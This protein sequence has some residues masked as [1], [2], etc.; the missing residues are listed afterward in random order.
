MQM[1]HPKTLE[2]LVH[3]ETVHRLSLAFALFLHL[4]DEIGECNLAFLT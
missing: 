1:L 4:L 2:Q 3:M